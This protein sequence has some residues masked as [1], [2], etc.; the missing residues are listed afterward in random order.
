MS[1]A[2]LESYQWMMDELEE[3]KNREV[4]LSKH[5]RVTNDP[6]KAMRMSRDEEEGDGISDCT[7]GNNTY[8]P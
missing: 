5:G 7:A 2:E 4:Y 3:Q 1:Y 6:T 8:D